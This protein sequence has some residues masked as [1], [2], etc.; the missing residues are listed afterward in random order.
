MVNTIL[1]D[2]D[3]TLLPFVQ[4][5]F[6]RAYFK[7]LV[8]RL[9]PMGYE[10]EKLVAAIW[11]GTN[12]MIANDGSRTNRQV[13]WESFVGDLG[14]AAMA[15][16]SILDDFYIRDFDGVRSV[17]RRPADRRELLLSLRR[18]GYGVVLA[19]NPIFP[20]VAVG[21]RL[22]WAGLAADDF[23]Y[24][25]TY[26]NSRYSKPELGY[27]RHILDQIG[28]RP[29]ECLMVGN[30]PVDDMSALKLGLEGY[31]VT[32]FLEDPAHTPLEAF[33]RGSFQEL[34]AFLGALPA[35]ER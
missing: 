20:A 13:F 7:A 19:T 23:D 24:V 12:A 4:E 14:V 5:E 16:E 21:T 31:L 32:D 18:R 35:V 33:R 34:E 22:N 17:L 6:I 3:G 15:L 30:N 27:Y 1:F 26:E 10:G 11:K 28:R 29:E 2:L 9:S 8:R 25:T